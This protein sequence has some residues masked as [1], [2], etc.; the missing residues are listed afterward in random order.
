M[1]QN[2]QKHFGGNFWEVYIH[3]LEQN[4]AYFEKNNKKVWPSYIHVSM[5]HIL[6]VL[7]PQL[8]FYTG[9][10]RQNYQVI[11]LTEIY[12]VTIKMLFTYKYFVLFDT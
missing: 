5:N 1:S 7:G 3:K 12:L 2:I 4:I 11:I 8:L 6:C 9:N 10:Y